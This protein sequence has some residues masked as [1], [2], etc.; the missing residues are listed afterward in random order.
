MS[1]AMQRGIGEK[2]RVGLTW[3]YGVWISCLL[4]AVLVLAGCGGGAIG[5]AQAPT[6]QDPVSPLPAP[7]ALPQATPSALPTVTPR[8]ISL[9][10]LHTNDNWGETEPCG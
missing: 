9:I 8:P 10:V 3:R 6:V 2:R 4:L 5:I 7:T 1:L